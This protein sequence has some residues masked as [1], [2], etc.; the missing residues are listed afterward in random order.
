MGELSR[1]H[2]RRHVGEAS[3]A[4][5]GRKAERTDMPGAVT[6]TYEGPNGMRGLQ[7]DWTIV[8]TPA[9]MCGGL[10]E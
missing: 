7:A 1:G 9:Q 2:S 4:L 10:S 5:Q 6:H 3:E 8:I